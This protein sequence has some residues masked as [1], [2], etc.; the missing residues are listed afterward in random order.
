MTES[1]APQPT[2]PPARRPG[3]PTGKA[4]AKSPLFALVAILLGVIGAALMA[5]SFL[6]GISVALDGS[7]GGSSIYIALFFIGV[8]LAVVGL[9]FSLVGL[10]RS[11]HRA[12]SVIGLIVALLPGLVVL[13]IAALLFL[14]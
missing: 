9:V 8:G 1:S 14:N 13:V 11:I 5:Y 12:L 2:T 7:S 4:P 6:T 3:A 10:A